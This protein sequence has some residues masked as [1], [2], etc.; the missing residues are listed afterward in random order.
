MAYTLHSIKVDSLK[1]DLVKSRSHQE[2]AV[3]HQKKAPAARL[4]RKNVIFQQK[5]A[6]AASLRTK[7]LHFSLKKAPAARLTRKN[8]LICFIFNTSCYLFHI[9]VSFCYFLTLFDTFLHTFS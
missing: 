4:T 8:E 1:V 3:F 2:N 6:P 5:K 7:K 9:F